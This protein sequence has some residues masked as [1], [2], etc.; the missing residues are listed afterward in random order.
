MP[1]SVFSKI[2]KRVLEDMTDRRGFRQE[3][4]QCDKDVQKE[5]L[6]AWEGIIR[7]TI[8]KE[9]GSPGVIY[10][11]CNHCGPN[12]GVDED[13]CCVACGS[14]AVGECTHLIDEMG[15]EI[16]VLK[17]ELAKRGK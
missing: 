15:V 3:W 17:Q 8:H 9:I 1:E 5:I 2:A 11:W 10:S 7:E 6:T 16:R 14:D 12:P 13:G 4:D